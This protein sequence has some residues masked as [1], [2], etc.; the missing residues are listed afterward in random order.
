M[1]YPSMAALVPSAIPPWNVT[2]SMVIRPQRML[3]S[4]VHQMCRNIVMQPVCSRRLA[5]RKTT[6]FLAADDH[7]SGACGVMVVRRAL[8]S[9]TGMASG[10]GHRHGSSRQCNGSQPA[11][12]Q[13]AA[14]Q[15][16][17]QCAPTGPAFMPSVLISSHPPS[18]PAARTPYGKRY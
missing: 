10:A 4:V 14:S 8:L 5:N 6:P 1:R 13:S 9:C 17:R 16:A 2:R 7:L 18:Q 3:V 12:S 11:S 15:P